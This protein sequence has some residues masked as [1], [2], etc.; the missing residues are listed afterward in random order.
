LGPGLGADSKGE[1]GSSDGRRET[2]VEEGLGGCKD[3]SV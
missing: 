1:D 3:G 2:H